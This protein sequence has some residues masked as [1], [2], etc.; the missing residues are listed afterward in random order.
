MTKAEFNEWKNHKVT[1]FVFDALKERQDG[2]KEF[3]ANGGTLAN[4]APK[5]A[6]AA[7]V[8]R[9]QG[10]NEVL[11]VEYEEPPKPYEY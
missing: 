2:L 1:Q 3:L 9:I 5:D 7:V 11:M 10:I 6:T 4:D 8:G